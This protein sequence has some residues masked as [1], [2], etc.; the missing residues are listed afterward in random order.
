MGL[1]VVAGLVGYGII[2][3]GVH[4]VLSSPSFYNVVEEAT[5]LYDGWIGWV[6]GIWVWR[7]DKDGELEVRR[8]DGEIQKK[9]VD[10][11]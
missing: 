9:G 11:E 3:D 1:I 10:V 7:G 5:C 6:V 2:R 8:G 4:V